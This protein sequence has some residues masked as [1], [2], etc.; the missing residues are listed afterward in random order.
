MFKI[1]SRRKL[2]LHILYSFLQFLKFA[3]Q[4]NG[5]DRRGQN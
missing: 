2:N 1:I 4:L 3:W 5:S